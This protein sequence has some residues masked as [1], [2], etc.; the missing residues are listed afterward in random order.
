M[1]LW[2]DD[3]RPAPNGWIW[4]TTISSA[5]ILLESG[6]V[7]MASLDHALGCCKECMTPDWHGNMPHCSHVGTGYDLCCWMAETRHWP[8]TKPAVH[9]MNPEGARRMREVISQHF[10]EA[11]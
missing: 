10:S 2:L 8:K 3:V 4:I 6:Y 1:K 9:S 5:K 11:Q 7:E